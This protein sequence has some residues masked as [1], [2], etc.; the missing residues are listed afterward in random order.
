MPWKKIAVAAGA[1]S[2]L[3]AAWAL[4]AFE[5]LGDPAR[6][7]E[8]LLRLGAL[9]YLAFLCAFALLQPFGLPGVILIVAASLVWPPAVAIALSLAG[10]TLASVTGFSFARYLAR[11]WVE[12][13]IPPRLRKYDDRLATKGF[14][15]VFVLRSFLWTN[16][17]VSAVFG[18]SRVS[19]STH[20]VASLLAYVAPV[21]AITLLG[22][23]AFTIARNQPRERWLIALAVLGTAAVGIWVVRRYRRASAPPQ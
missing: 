7:R 4:G 11:D 19:F 21:V 16:Q 9:G 23:A 10:A 3:A 15:T 17:A 6:L 22:D 8:S 13:R 14:A 5:V 12:K 1:A 2:M 20:L 18:L